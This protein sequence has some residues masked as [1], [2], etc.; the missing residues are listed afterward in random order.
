MNRQKSFENEK[1]TL[2]LVP[3]PIGNL[4][5]M[6]PRAIDVLNSVDVIA[7]EDTRNSGQLLKHFDISKRLIAYQNFNEASS[8]K[9]IINL[10][11]QGNNIAL[12]SDAGY[13]LIN[14][15]GQRVV[16]EV[17]ALGYNVVPI[18]GCSA[19]LNALVASGLIAQPFIFIGFLPPSTHDCVKKL[20]LYQSYPMTLIMYE[21]PHRIEK[22]LQSCLDVL[23][24]RHIC[25]G[26]ELTKVHEEFIRGTISEILP[27][28]SELKGEMV[29]VIEGNQDDYEKDIDMGQILNMVNTSIESGMSTSAAIKEVAKQTGIPK[30]QIYDL[31]HGKTDQKGVC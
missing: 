18:S 20:R 4:N 24:D 3:T 30:N 23:G 12:I 2:Y 19:F 26:R 10:L 13:P 29:V 7:C 15:P 22:M 8:T 6:T 9:G 25:I 31:V 5:E 16:S 14:D 11:S 28:A 21:A 1:P 17:T 27:I